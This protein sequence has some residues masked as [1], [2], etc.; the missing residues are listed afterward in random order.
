MAGQGITGKD[1]DAKLGTTQIAEVTK[2][3]WTT[4]Q[5]IVS[6]C[7]NKTGGYKQRKAGVKEGNGTLEGVWDPANPAYSQVPEGI[8]ALTLKL[9]INATQ[10]W[11]VTAIIEQFQNDVNI[12]AGEMVTWSANFFSQGQW[13][14]PVSALMLDPSQEP[15]EGLNM[16]LPVFTPVGP[17][18]T[19]GESDS[20]YAQK[21]AAFY[22]SLHLPEN[23]EEV[24]Q[25]VIER[26]EKIRTPE[27]MEEMISRA[28]EKAALSLQNNMIDAVTT[29]IMNRLAQAGLSTAA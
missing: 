26:T 1:G 27:G 11:S 22:Q 7:S 15:P 16:N 20:Q 12:D 21:L 6:Y 28:A 23:M 17:P 24:V 8:D 9:Y 3:S 2:W 18:R 14:A 25:K 19:D 4:K 10:F 13:T 5:N 29:A